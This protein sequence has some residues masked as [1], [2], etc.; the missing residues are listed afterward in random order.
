MFDGIDRLDALQNVFDRVVDRIFAGFQRQAL[1][2]HVLQRDDLAADLLLRQLFARD[3]AVFLMIRA[4][5][6]AVYTVVGEVQ[7][8]EHHDAVAVELLLD[9]GSLRKNA[10]QRVLVLAGKQDGR[11]PVRQSLEF[12]GLVDQAVDQF[13]VVFVFVRIA[14][15]IANF[16]IVDK[17]GCNGGLWIIHIPSSFQ[18]VEIHTEKFEIIQA[19]AASNGFP[20]RFHAGRC[21]YPHRKK[22]PDRFGRV[23]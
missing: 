7:R 17:F 16:L 15:R 8:C 2:A 22:T 20:L 5:G 10:L 19:S 9:L 21:G 23:F 18:S 14:E 4:I 13:Q 6:A 12:V 1:V 3:M 11:F